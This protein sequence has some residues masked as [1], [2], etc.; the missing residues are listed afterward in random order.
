MPPL[1]AMAAAR[2]FDL[3]LAELGFVGARHQTVGIVEPQ[4]AGASRSG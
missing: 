2:V 3:G 1:A 4:S